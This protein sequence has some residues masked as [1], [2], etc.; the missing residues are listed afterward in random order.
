MKPEANSAHM[1]SSQVDGSDSNSSVVL[2]TIT[3][4]TV[5][6]LDVSDW[7]LD[8]GATYHVC[9]G[10]D[11]FASFEKLDDCLVQMGDDST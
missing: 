2:L 4:P 6:Y 9:L 3:I 10:R 11:W 1:K 5:C 7:I 8:M